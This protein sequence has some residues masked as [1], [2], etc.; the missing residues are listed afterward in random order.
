MG[1]AESYDA[2][3]DRAWDALEAERA[4]EALGLCDRA[5]RL[6]PKGPDAH[7]VRG[8]ALW[9]RE[10]EDEAVAEF[11]RCLAL[12]D[13]YYEAMLAKAAAVLEMGAD[14]EEAVARCARALAWGPGTGGGGP[15]GPCAPPPIRRRSTCGTPGSSTA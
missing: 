10:R 15:T 5:L 4:E 7:Y 12:D 11:D 9:D 8:R 6:E 13:A 2:L 14:P 3:M 1:R